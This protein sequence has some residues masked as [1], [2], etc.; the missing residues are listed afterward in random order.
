[1]KILTPLLFV[2]IASFSSLA[3]ENISHFRASFVEI[4]NY[5]TAEA[6][7]ATEVSES[8]FSFSVTIRS[9]KAVCKMMMAQ[10]VYNP[11][12]KYSWFNKGKTLL[13]QSIVLDKNV[14]NIY[15]RLI[16]QINV[17]SFLGYKTE[18]ESDTKYI[19]ENLE[20]SAIPEETKRFILK[21]LINT[22]ELET[23]KPLAKKYNVI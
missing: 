21:N 2:I 19:L 12:T 14:E 10:Y 3:G 5:E 18:I 8:N 23:M 1:M 7:L 4:K 9:Y 15:L 6:F 20:K 16:V 13:E 17:P 22:G 11:F